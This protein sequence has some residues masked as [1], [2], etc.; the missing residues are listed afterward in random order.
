MFANVVAM[1]KPGAARVDL[2]SWYVLFSD[3]AQVHIKPCSTVC[4]G[5]ALLSFLMV[6][7]RIMRVNNMLS[8]AELGMYSGCRVM[9][10]NKG[11]G[12]KLARQCR[13]SA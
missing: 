6:S 10:E 8:E 9:F 1:L 12:F 13:F 7:G 5:Y 2:V 3:L 11:L 4:G